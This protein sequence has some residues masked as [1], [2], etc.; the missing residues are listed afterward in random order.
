MSLL[1][2]GSVF[3]FDM[4]IEPAPGSS[5]YQIIKESLELLV[6][7]ESYTF[8]KSRIIFKFN[9]VSMEITPKSDP[10]KLAEYYL[11]ALHKSV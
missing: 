9:G 2:S 6:P 11:N 7:F 3:G 10:K 8:T 5:I 1:D 4:E